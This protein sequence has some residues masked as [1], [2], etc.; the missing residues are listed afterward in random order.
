MRTAPSHTGKCTSTH[1]YP[2]SPPSPTPLNPTTTE[3][4]TRQMLPCRSLVLAAA[5]RACLRVGGL[6]QRSAL[7]VDIGHPLIEAKQGAQ[8]GRASAEGP[9]G[10]GVGDGVCLEDAAGGRAR[11]PARHQAL[12]GVATLWLLPV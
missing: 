2:T 3:L 5:S 9:G 12:G 7:L 6:L 11:G 10:S 8:A 4:T 1:A